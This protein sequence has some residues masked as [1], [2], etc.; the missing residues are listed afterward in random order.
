MLRWTGLQHKG[1]VGQRVLD[2]LLPVLRTPHMKRPCQAFA[3]GRVVDYLMSVFRGCFCARF[4]CPPGLPVPAGMYVRPPLAGPGS[5]GRPGPARFFLL[6][7]AQRLRRPGRP[8]GPSPQA[9]RS[10]LDAGGAAPLRF[11]P[12]QRPTAGRWRP[13]RVGAV[14]RGEMVA[15]ATA[16]L[17]CACRDRRSV[18]RR[19][20]PRT[21]TGRWVAQGVR[22]DRPCHGVR[23][24][25]PP[26]LRGREGHRVSWSSRPTRTRRARGRSRSPPPRGSSRA[27]S[28]WYRWRAAAAAPSTSG[29]A[30]PRRTRPAG[31]AA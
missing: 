28:A 26:G 2:L 23:P 12:G 14:R 15:C 18:F 25:A 4:T 6:G 7:G 30:S 8:A 31:A 27:G 10:S 21:D 13:G 11:R 5:G 22:G 9:M 1:A 20:G 24:G 29:P 19:A 17:I 16:S 3:G